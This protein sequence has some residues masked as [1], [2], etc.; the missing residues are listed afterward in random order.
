MEID[1]SYFMKRIII[2][3][4]SFIF[5]IFF[6]TPTHAQSDTITLRLS[7]DWGYGGP[8]GRIEGTFSMRVSGPENMSEVRFFIDAEMVAID[9]TSPFQYQFKTGSFSPGQHTL[10]A[11][12]TLSDGTELQASTMQR[13]FLTKD[14]ANTDTRGLVIPIL[15]GVGAITLIATVVPLLLGKKREHK[16]GEYGMAGGAI[17]PRCTYPYSRNYLSPN[18]VVGKL[19]RCPHCG[20]WAIARRATQGALEE[21][22]NRLAHR[23]KGSSEDHAAKTAKGLEKLIDESRFED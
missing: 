23:D 14:E 18:L 13:T 10:S 8:N 6:P 4:I 7:R 3:I 15:V 1:W 5:V 17:C 22:E 19:E 16:P 12:G 20:K 2:A 21:A 9:T 11:S